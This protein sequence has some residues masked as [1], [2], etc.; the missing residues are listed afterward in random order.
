MELNIEK[1]RFDSMKK[2][3]FSINVSCKESIS[4][5]AKVL[6]I[7]AYASCGR[8]E[9]L[10]NEVVIEGVVR[11]TAIIKENDEIKKVERSERFTLSDFVD[12]VKPDS[13]M[14][15]F[16][17]VSKVRGYIEAGKLMLSCAVNVNALIINSEEVEYVKELPEDYRKK[18]KELKVFNDSLIKTLR[19][20]INDETELSPRLPEVKDILISNAFVTVKEARVTAG[21]LI[22]AGEISLQTLYNSIDEF[23]PIFQVTD[24]FD[25]SQ[26]IDINEEMNNPFVVLNIEDINSNVKPN[27]QGE[28]RIIEYNIGLYGYAVESNEVKCN[29]VLDSYSLKNKTDCEY[30]EIN[31]SVLGEEFNSAINKSISVKVPEGSKHISRINS[32]T[33]NPEVVESNVIDSKIFLKCR[34]EVNAIYTVSG[35]EETDGFNTTVE[36]DFVSENMLIEDAED[37]ITYLSLSDMQAFL[38]SGNEIEI[39]AGFNLK[40]IPKY[41]VNEK[42]VCNIKVSEKNDFPDF[43]IIIFNVQPGEDLWGICKKYGVD[44]EEVTKLNPNISNVLLSGGKIYLFRKISI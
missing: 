24:K 22:L 31:C 30:T 25:F 37:V 3:T 29:V 26:L 8:S 17:S 7:N 4:D 16:V 21:Q 32:V 14:N 40:F 6:G 27:E 15:T 20:G 43:G 9:M 18:E 39:R 35:A 23:E 34:G 41:S 2:R 13:K 38:I 36:F 11:Y 44:E 42:I 28:M 12:D 5:S 33:F 19:F 10:S 1:I